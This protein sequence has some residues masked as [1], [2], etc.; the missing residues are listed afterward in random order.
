[1]LFSL[2]ALKSKNLITNFYPL[3]TFRLTNIIS[4]VPWDQCP[5]V[6]GNMFWFPF[7]VQCISKLL[8]FKK[9]Y[10]YIEN[11]LEFLDKREIC[12]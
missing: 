6:G 1:M 11:E 5:L 10:G 3:G 8:Y 7:H 2:E 4:C 12:F 9:M